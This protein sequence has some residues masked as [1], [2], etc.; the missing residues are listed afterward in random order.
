[1][2]TER[3]WSSNHILMPLVALLGIA[4]GLLLQGGSIGAIG[5]DLSVLVGALLVVLVSARWDNSRSR[6]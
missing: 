6:R 3:F 4:I 1:M 2:K 5:V